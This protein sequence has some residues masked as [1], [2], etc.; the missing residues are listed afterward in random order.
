[1]LIGCVLTLCGASFAFGQT[2]DRV[3]LSDLVAEAVAKN[4]EVAAAR[5]RYDA[6]SQRPTQEHALP[7]PLL[8]A[9]YSANGQPWPGAGLGTQPTS[10]IGFMV[11]QPIP[12]AGKR[13]LRASIARR[14]A[15]AEFQQIDAARQSVTA[16]VAQAYYRMAYTYA[17]TEVL[18]RNRD[19]L[20]TL[21]HVSESR[22]TVGQA[23][24]QDVI[25]AQ[26]QISI[27]DVQLERLRQERASYEGVLNALLTR[28]AGTTV[29]RPEDLSLTAFD[30]TL[31][32]LLAAA[33]QHAPM[34]RRDQIMVDRAQLAVDA[35]RKE[36][37]PDFSINGG[38][39]YMGSMPAMYEFRF[40]VT[41]PLQR[42]RRAAAV[43]EQVRNVEAAKHSVESTRLDLQTRIQND[44]EMAT[45]SR[46]LASLYRDTVLPQA[47]L[48]LESSLASYQTGRVDFL[49]VVTNFGTVLQYEISSLEELA[50]YLTA[51][52]RLEELTGISLVH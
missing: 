22:Y 39:Y 16:R 43:A 13:D 3:R 21:L 14:E 7:D 23:A 50:S 26:T 20:M 31:D 38:Y 52:S 49:S 6:A 45:T 8:S 46:K 48:A 28:P 2:G 42:A 25:N 51:V 15:D 35:A 36:Y 41:V 34:L 47:R 24:Q 27:I 12:Y 9:G 1:M 30:V 19:L 11:S 33:A 10:N 44:F 29:G 17:V 40:D 32:Q 4:P 37:H 5:S 18:T